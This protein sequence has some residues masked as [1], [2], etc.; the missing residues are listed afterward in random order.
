MKSDEEAPD[1]PS[2]RFTLL[3]IIITALITGLLVDVILY[4]VVQLERGTSTVEVLGIATVFTL[5]F[6]GSLRLTA[7]LMRTYFPLNSFHSLWVYISVNGIVVIAAFFA[8]A[9]LNELLFPGLEIINFESAAFAFIFGVSVVACIMGIIIY[10]SRDFYQRLK[11]AEAKRHESQLSALMAQ[12]DPHFLFN[13]LNSIAALIRTHPEKAE[14]VTEDL[15]GLFRYTLQS[16]RK[17]WVLLKEELEA[18]ETYIS[19]EKARFGD[20][21]KYTSDVENNLSDIPVP[22]LILQT[23]IENCI[24]HGANQS[25]DPFGIHAAVLSSGGMLHLEVT[26]N[27]PGFGSVPES[28]ILQRGS[29]LATIKERLK[30][31]YGERGRLAINGRTV[32]LEFPVR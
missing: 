27:G 5:V 4:Q 3:F 24:K 13:S 29:G 32:T 30:L 21:L 11:R 31:H 25:L 14:S 15:A 9:R 23:I 22:G 12:T 18:V 16:S 28:E 26:D 7:R 19:I 20:Q 2:W 10:F 6:T 8:A 17:E 1:T